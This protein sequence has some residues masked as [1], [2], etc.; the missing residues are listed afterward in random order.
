MSK[1]CPY[2]QKPGY[3]EDILSEWPAPAALFMDIDA[4]FVARLRRKFPGL[5]IVVRLYESESHGWRKT[6]P[7]D[8]AARFAAVGPDY[9]ISWTMFVG[10]DNADLFA[11]FDDWSVRFAVE[12]RKHGIEPVGL[13]VGT[14]NF[15]G[16]EDRIRVSDAFPG[17]CQYYN[18]LGPQDYGWPA[19]ESQ[20]PWHALRWTKW[21]D[22]IEEAFGKEMAF[23]PMECGITQAVL[24]G[25]PDVGWQTYDD[26]VT[27]ES[28]L[29]TMRW[30][31]ERL[32]QLHYAKYAFVY[33]FHG[34]G[35]WATFD[36]VNK[37]EVWHVMKDFDAA[38]E[39][40]PEEQE[41]PEE[42]MTDKIKVV[43]LEYQERDLAY[44]ES[45]YGVAFRRADVEPG[46]KV[47]RLV[48][49]NEKT[50]DSSLITK[51]LGED[52][53]PK[54]NMYVAFYWPDAPKEPS[55]HANDWHKNFVHGP[56]NTN[57]DVGPGLGPGAYHGEGEG[58]PH[59]VW[60]RDP[61]I[62]SDI[63]ERLGMLAGTFHDHL[64]QKFRLVVH[65]GEEQ[66]PP[67]GEKVLKFKERI[68]EDHESNML[69]VA[70]DADYAVANDA[71]GDFRGP[72]IGGKPIH[73]KEWHHPITGERM[74]LI[75]GCCSF[76]GAENEARK[77]TMQVRNLRTSGWLTEEHPE[78]FPSLESGMGFKRGLGL[79]SG[80]NRLD[81]PGRVD[82]ALHAGIADGAHDLDH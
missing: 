76:N 71:R 10:Q 29:A 60:V 13:C 36:H 24:E 14:G 82:L 7:E 22:D 32:C 37:P 58:G 70:I 28:Y 20:V 17:I 27:D 18:V 65:Q 66:K 23:M 26:G 68:T 61:D 49:L 25:R 67:T 8:W 21:H 80:D 77:Y 43:D 11:E 55:A 44:A 19:L 1:L 46:Q 75:E 12:V 40:P 48:E 33:I 64:D 56:T 72:G 53:N 78:T 63:C 62:P 54:A 16:A 9:A 3:G 74:A 73:P 4:D 2:F 51:V 50:G 6:A 79:A 35:D 52:G 81:K 59:A 57:G 38:V 47:Y 69:G 5:K 42:P 31:N 34:Y 39:P 41:P 45:K 15:T 30:Y